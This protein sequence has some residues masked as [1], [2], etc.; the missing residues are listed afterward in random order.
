MPSGRRLGVH[1][2]IEQAIA[3]PDRLL[4]GER[5]RH[6]VES[7]SVDRMAADYRRVYDS[8]LA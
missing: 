4:R 8:V 6:H 2:V 3:A 5:A 7:Y 1:L